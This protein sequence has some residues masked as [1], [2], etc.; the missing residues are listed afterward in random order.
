MI[1]YRRNEDRYN[2]K[3]GNLSFEKVDDLKYLGVN[4]NSSNKMHMGNK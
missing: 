2:W 3:V 1:L 4:V